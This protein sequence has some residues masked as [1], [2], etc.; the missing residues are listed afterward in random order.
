MIVT[1]QAFES[2]LHHAVGKRVRIIRPF[3]QFDK[4][5][6]M[7]LGQGMPLESTFSCISPI[8]RLHCGQCNK[9]AERQ[10]AFRSVGADDP[11]EYAENQ[12]RTS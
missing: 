12:V 4:R 8:D 1:T 3:E 9:C 5:K 10:A 2:A 11:T 6:V 7:E